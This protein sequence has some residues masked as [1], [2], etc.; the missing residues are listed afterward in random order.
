MISPESS[1][2]THQDTGHANMSFTNA[3]QTESSFREPHAQNRQGG[4]ARQ[5]KE[6]NEE[7]KKVSDVGK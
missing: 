4:K 7:K 3:F 2:Y 1:L 5:G 6:G